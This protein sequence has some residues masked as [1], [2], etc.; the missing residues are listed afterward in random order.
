MTYETLQQR[1]EEAKSSFLSVKDRIPPLEKKVFDL[2]GKWREA[3]INGADDKKL[4][5]IETEI[6]RIEKQL[7]LLRGINPQKETFQAL[8]KD[9]KLKEECK[10][11]TDQQYKILDEMMADEAKLSEAVNA[12]FDTLIGNI[13][14]WRQKRQGIAAICTQIGEISP[15]IDETPIPSGNLYASYK[16]R[17]AIINPATMAVRI[18]TA[19][20]L[21]P[22]D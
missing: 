19:S 2:S 5:S 14:V 13:K 10:S 18:R 16:S 4:A 15:Y 1:I 8:R 20:G 7:E 6:T 3:V 21:P 11:F 17:M 22:E 9:K 12:S